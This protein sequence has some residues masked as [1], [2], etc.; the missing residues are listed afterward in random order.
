MMLG[1]S[2]T[3]NSNRVKSTFIFFMLEFPFSSMF[4]ECWHLNVLL[5]H[6]FIITH[7]LH[8]QMLH[9]QCEY[10]HFKHELFVNAWI[11]FF[12]IIAFL[13]SKWNSIRYAIVWF[14]VVLVTVESRFGL[15]KWWNH[16]NFLIILFCRHIENTRKRKVRKKFICVIQLNAW[17]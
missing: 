8:K 2:R 3:Y 7:I 13:S 5:Y 17:K 10:A 14:C 15:H 9:I 12:F 1:I 11:I 4:D 6:P 16:G